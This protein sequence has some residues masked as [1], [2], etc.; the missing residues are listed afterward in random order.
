M[1]VISC[2]TPTPQ[3]SLCRNFIRHSVDGPGE[4][5]IPQSYWL[6][7]ETEKLCWVYGS[8]WESGSMP[9]QSFTACRNRCLHPRYF[10]CAAAHKR[11]LGCKQKLRHAVNDNLGLEDV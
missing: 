4:L 9:S 1:T 8:I 2:E 10:L 7:L 11:Y 5:S 6:F 3:C